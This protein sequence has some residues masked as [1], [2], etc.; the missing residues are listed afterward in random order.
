M[1]ALVFH[2]SFPNRPKGHCKNVDVGQ[3]QSDAA[4]S[5]TNVQEPFHTRIPT[6]KAN[7][8]L[9]LEIVKMH[10]RQGLR[11]IAN[12]NWSSKISVHRIFKRNYF[13]PYGIHLVKEFKKCVTHF[14]RHIVRMFR[15][16]W[17]ANWAFDLILILFIYL[18]F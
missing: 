3:I 5:V 7:D 14:W 15:A 9:K 18:F 6:N 4:V 11:E 16:K 1:T 12:K 17:R 2:D 13:H 8:V 10:K